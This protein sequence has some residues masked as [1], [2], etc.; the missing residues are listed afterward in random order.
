[1]LCAR[2]D[3]LLLRDLNSSSLRMIYPRFRSMDDCYAARPI[4]LLREVFYARG[5]DQ[6]SVRSATRG[7][8]CTPGVAMEWD[9]SQSAIRKD[10][11]RADI[12]RARIRFASALVL[13]A[14]CHAARAAQADPPVSIT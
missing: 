7:L 10:A 13:L 4:T 11:M 6:D 3:H 9:A 8:G 2:V 5:F 12:W 14:R 1:M